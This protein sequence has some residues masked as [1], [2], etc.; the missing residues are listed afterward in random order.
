MLF[1]RYIDNDKSLFSSSIVLHCG[2][3]WTCV[4]IQ[5]DY[6]DSHAFL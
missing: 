3:I 1:V 6:T 5:R 4:V 2:P